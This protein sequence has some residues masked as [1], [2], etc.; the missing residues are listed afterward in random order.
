MPRSKLSG[1]VIHSSFARPYSS[2][3]KSHARRILV[4]YQE[5]EGLFKEQKPLF[6]SRNMPVLK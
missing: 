3:G 5:H 6:P 4:V 1:L 2:V